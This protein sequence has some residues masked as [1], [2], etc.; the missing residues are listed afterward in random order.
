[1][2]AKTF[3]VGRIGD[4]VDYPNTDASED[5]D[6]LHISTSWASAIKQSDGLHVQANVTLTNRSEGIVTIPNLTAE[7][8]ANRGNVGV[9]SSDNAV[10]SLLFIAE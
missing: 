8:Q 7:F 10:R 4:K 5:L 6:G 3:A 2:S 9:T 1:M